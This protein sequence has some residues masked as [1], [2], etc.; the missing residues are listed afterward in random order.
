[1]LLDWLDP[2]RDQAGL[3]YE[4][5]RRGLIVMFNQR[6]CSRAEELADET[7]NRVARKVRTL[8]QSYEGD[9]R[10]Y[11]FGVAK[12]VCLESYQVRPALPP[13][14][15]AATEPD[16][17]ESLYECLE[18]CMEELPPENREIILRYYLG[19]K[20]AKINSRKELSQDLNLQPGALRVRAHRIRGTLEECIRRCMK[21]KGEA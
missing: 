7:I 15:V 21:Q 14:S 9:P 4:S 12:N 5:I 17:N 20:R 6:R 13:G 10:N 8:A 2:D 19:E 1:M 18:R 16:D 11:F 3:Q